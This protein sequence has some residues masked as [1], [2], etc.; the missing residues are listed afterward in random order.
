MK[1]LLLRPFEQ[2]VGLAS[3]ELRAVG[4]NMMS[5]AVKFVWRLQGWFDLH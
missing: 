5:L 4:A 3:F 2:K 1:V